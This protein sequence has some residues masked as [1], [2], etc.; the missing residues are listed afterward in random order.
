VDDQNRSGNRWEPEDGQAQPLESHQGEQAEAPASPPI[1]HTT[2][3]T[4]PADAETPRPRDDVPPGRVPR[5]WTRWRNEPR[6][7]L[8][9]G[10]AVAV[11]MLVVGVGGF[12]IGRVTAPDGFNGFD[13]DGRPGFGPGQSQRQGFDSDDSDE[14]GFPQ[15]RGGTDPLREGGTSS[16]EGNADTTLNVVRSTW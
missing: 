12:A 4:P 16:S 3:L 14:Q 6:R 11:L 5:D 8:L 2:V 13:G 7:S 15:P 9:L 1:A 10:I